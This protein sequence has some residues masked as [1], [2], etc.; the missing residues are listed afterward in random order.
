[1]TTWE[2]IAYPCVVSQGRLEQVWLSARSRRF[3]PVPLCRPETDLL[4][5]QVL[6]QKSNGRR[7]LTAATRP[8]SNRP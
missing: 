2:L 5:R 6:R 3:G 7:I 1:M 8:G 4:N